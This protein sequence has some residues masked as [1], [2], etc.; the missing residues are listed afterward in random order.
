MKKFIFVFLI[1]ISTNLFSAEAGSSQ[2]MYKFK[3]CVKDA[4][5]ENEIFSFEKEFPSGI[6]PSQIFALAQQEKAFKDYFNNKVIKKFDL[7]YGYTISE[8]PAHFF[9][10]LWIETA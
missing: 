8:T 3:I 2:P 10:E 1:L 4:S 9:F 5:N 7:R 6:V